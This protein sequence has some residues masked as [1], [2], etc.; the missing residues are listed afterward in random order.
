[1]DPEPREGHQSQPSDNQAPE[2]LTSIHGA[3]TVS[4]PHE[5]DADE[6]D[7]L[8]V[9]QFLQTLAEVA[10]AVASRKVQP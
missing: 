1:V 3:Y 2:G 8:M 7:S 5:P 6:V 10:L 4:T 9:R